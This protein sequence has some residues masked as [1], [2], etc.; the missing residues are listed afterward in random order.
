MKNMTSRYVCVVALL[1]LLSCVLV[2]SVLISDVWGRFQTQNSANDN[3]RLASYVIAVDI[4]DETD[5]TIQL[6]ISDLS[7]TNPQKTF[8]IIVSN[9]KGGKTSEVK[10][11]YGVDARLVGTLPISCSLDSD[12]VTV[13]NNKAMGA[14]PA[15]QT[16]HRYT[17]TV[18]WDADKIVQ[19]ADAD[20]YD[21]ISFLTLLFHT[22]Q[23][24]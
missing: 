1:F 14:L 21:D 24:D 11:N 13:S 5:N 2:S 4:Q 10:Q 20:I 19:S 3:A 18:K 23:A 15:E 12:D 17:L 22:E 9:T 8:T 7:S 16:E 6:D